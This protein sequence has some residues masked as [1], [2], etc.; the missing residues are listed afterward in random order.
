MKMTFSHLK[1]YS[2]VLLKFVLVVLI[3]H[4]FKVL[5]PVEN[6]VIIVDF[7]GLAEMPSGFSVGEIILNEVSKQDEK[8]SD[9]A[10]FIRKQIL[11]RKRKSEYLKNLKNFKNVKSKCVIKIALGVLSIPSVGSTRNLKAVSHNNI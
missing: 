8:I 2:A 9:N 10:S 7:S 6:K 11:D 5:T 3:L 1:P 4:F